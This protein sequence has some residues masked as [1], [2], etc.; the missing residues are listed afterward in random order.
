MIRAYSVVW[1]PFSA[2]HSRVANGTVLVGMAAPFKRH[3]E[4]NHGSDR[5]Q[6]FKA[7]RDPATVGTTVSSLIAG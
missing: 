3:A 7:R 2:A 1:L 4:V 6:G 5:V